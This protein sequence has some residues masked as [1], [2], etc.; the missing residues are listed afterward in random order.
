MGENQIMLPMDIFLKIIEGQAR[1]EAKLDSHITAES[2]LTARV[3]NLESDNNQAKGARKMLVWL[4]PILSALA[5]I[6]GTAVAYAVTIGRYIEQLQQ[7]QTLVR[8]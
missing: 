5:S 7:L 2:M 6:I 4:V 3:S 8:P 1:I